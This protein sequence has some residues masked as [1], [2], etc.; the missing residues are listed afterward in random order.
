MSEQPW[1]ALPRGIADVLRPVIADV[2]DEVIDAVRTIPAYARPL[3]GPFGAGLRTG[4]QEAFRHF[5]A[6]IEASGPV[7]RTDV[8]VTLGRGEMRAGRSLESLLTA[9]RVGARV[10]WRRFASAG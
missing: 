4:V 1:H 2:A 8:Y 5:L 9:Y 10:A 3:D 6:E 7:P